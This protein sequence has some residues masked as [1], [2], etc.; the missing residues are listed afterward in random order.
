VASERMRV[1]VGMH[2]GVGLCMV[3]DSQANGTA[4]ESVNV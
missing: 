3:G 4:H 2:D 1:S